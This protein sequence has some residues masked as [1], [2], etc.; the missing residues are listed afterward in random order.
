VTVVGAAFLLPVDWAVGGVH[1]EHDALCFVATLGLRDQL[2][3]HCHQS[4]QIL[5]VGEHAGLKALQPG[6]E[7]LS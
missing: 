4:D 5:V 3:I 2:A 6:L 7:P 1:I